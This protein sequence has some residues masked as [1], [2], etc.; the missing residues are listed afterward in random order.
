MLSELL[1]DGELPAFGYFHIFFLRI[2]YLLLRTYCT[3]KTC[4]RQALFYLKK[5]DPLG[6]G[7]V[8]RNGKESVLVV[9]AHRWLSSLP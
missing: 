3:S 8:Y 2:S 6:V 9:T 1:G 4:H 5:L 7:K